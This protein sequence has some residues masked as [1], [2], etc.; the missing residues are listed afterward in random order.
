VRTFADF[1]HW[2]DG[3]PSPIGGTLKVDPV[4]TG[5][6]LVSSFK[7]LTVA[8]GLHKLNATGSPGFRTIQ[9]VLTAPCALPR[10]P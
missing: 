6:L 3:S 1:D 9:P 7:H 4:A 8:I 5:Q 2:A 10:T